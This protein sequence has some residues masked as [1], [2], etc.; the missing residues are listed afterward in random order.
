[1]LQLSQDISVGTIKKNHIQACKNQIIP[2][3]L[4]SFPSE[5]SR[6][7][8]MHQLQYIPPE[9]GTLATEEI[10]DEKQVW[11]LLELQATSYGELM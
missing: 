10:V 9:Q 1:M 3:D 11:D 5:D 6:H 4:L 2:V 7:D 8:R